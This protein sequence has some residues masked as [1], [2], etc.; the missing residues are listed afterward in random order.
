MNWKEGSKDKVCLRRKEMGLSCAV[1]GVMPAERPLGQRMCLEIRI[2]EVV[3]LLLF[4]EPR[5]RMTCSFL[6]SHEAK[7]KTTMRYRHS[8][9]SKEFH[10][11]CPEKGQQ[12][13]QSVFSKEGVFKISKC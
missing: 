6:A 13:A 10:K 12:E 5:G 7:G 8:D 11:S 1:S 3:G 9:P 4:I 2:S